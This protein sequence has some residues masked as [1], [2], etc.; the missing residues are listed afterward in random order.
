MQT[1]KGP[2]IAVI[3]AGV[4][5]WIVYLFDREMSHWGIYTI[6]D[7]NTHE[8]LAIVPLVCMLGTIVWLI[9]LITASIKNK[10]FKSNMVM[11][12]LLTILLAMQGNSVISQSNTVS[13]V[14]VA[15]VVNIEPQKEEITIRNELG[16]VVLNCPMPIFELLE[17]D[18]EYLID[19]QH[20]KE[21]LNK[22]KVNLVQIIDH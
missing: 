3:L 7:Y 11:I 14:T 10:N 12:V 8:L 17:L 5:L 6:V 21:T 19:Y 22:G 4:C 15:R 16:E 2:S 18:K 1:N 9:V 13:T 20:Q